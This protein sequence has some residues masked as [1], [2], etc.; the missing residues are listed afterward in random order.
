[1]I[2]R[3]NK[4]FFDIKLHLLD[5]IAY[6]PK[7]NSR[8]NK[9]KRDSIDNNEWVRRF[10][11]ISRKMRNRDYSVEKPC[12]SKFPNL[13]SVILVFTLFPRS[14]FLLSF[15]FSSCLHPLEEIPYALVSINEWSSKR[16]RNKLSRRMEG[17]FV[18]F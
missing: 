8:N 11:G 9:E 14:F 5:R 6:T 12:K 13:R 4:S 15:F 16:K 17:I 10:L 3:K 1:M 2:S 7:Y 18:K